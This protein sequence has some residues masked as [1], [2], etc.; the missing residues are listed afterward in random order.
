MST[1]TDV[2]DSLIKLG[3]PLLGAALPVPGGTAIGIALA[4]AISAPSA[5]PTDILAH[6]TQNAEALQK[7]HEFEAT[8]EETILKIT[9][10]AEQKASEG[11]T[12]RWKADMS[13]DS[14]L[15]KNIRPMVLIYILS[16]Y[17][18]FSLASG[19]GFNI[20]ENYV[21]LLGQWGMV[22]MSAYFVGRSVEKVKKG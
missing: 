16:L 9:V 22:V 5:S 1:W 3:L 19:A 10:D 8:H 13:S 2:R 17:A 12:D 7:A 20:N 21:S 11:V 18:I 6:L 4:N 15:A 14:W